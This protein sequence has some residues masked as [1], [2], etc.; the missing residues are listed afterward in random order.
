MSAPRQGDA[1]AGRTMQQQA[2]AGSE[3]SASFQRRKWKHR[4]PLEKSKQH[5][6][7]SQNR[8]GENKGFGL[9]P[10]LEK[11]L[12][13]TLHP[14]RMN[15]ACSGLRPLTSLFI[16]IVLKS[17]G[18]L[19]VWPALSAFTVVRMRT[20]SGEQCERFLKHSHLTVYSCVEGLAAHLRVTTSATHA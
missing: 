20:Q 18:P 6:F 8:P 14:T 7:K 5:C 3:V 2:E 13:Q 11:M 15:P 17:S 16:R 12:S 9:D 4:L 1:H 19:V 10:S